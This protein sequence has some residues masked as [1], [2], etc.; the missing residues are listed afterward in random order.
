[1]VMQLIP[2]EVSAP[3]FY[4]DCI[5]AAFLSKGLE[6]GVKTAVETPPLVGLMTPNL[7]ISWRAGMCIPCPFIHFFGLQSF[8]TFSPV[9][10]DVVETLHDGSYQKN[11]KEAESELPFLLLLHMDSRGCVSCL[12]FILFFLSGFGSTGFI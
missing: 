7:E 8:N 10:P 5:N 9:V 12:T 3:L 4:R 6:K 2:P 1:M 11:H